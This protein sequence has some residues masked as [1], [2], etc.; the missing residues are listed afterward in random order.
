MKQ[1][2]TVFDKI[3]NAVLS[4]LVL[5]QAIVLILSVLWRYVFHAPFIWI[6]EVVRYLLVWVSFLGLGH[7]VRNHK[8]I[9]VNVIDSYIPPKAARFLN[10]LR[11]IIIF[12]F[13]MIMIYFSSKVAFKQM[14]VRGESLAWLRFGYLYLAIA[15]GSVIGCGYLIREFKLYAK[16]ADKDKT[17]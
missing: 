8:H 7:V 10:I 14:V 2:L 6:D 4:Y 16:K 12:I 3:L 5:M 13:L 17:V 15:V 1:V 11:D 9:A